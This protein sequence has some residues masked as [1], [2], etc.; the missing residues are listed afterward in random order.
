MTLAAAV[1]FSLSQNRLTEFADRSRQ[2]QSLSVGGIACP[3]GFFPYDNPKAAPHNCACEPQ[4][5]F[6]PTSSVWKMGNTYSIPPFFKLWIEV[7]ILAE[8]SCQIMRCCHKTLPFSESYPKTGV[9]IL[10]QNSTLSFWHWRHH[11]FSQLPIT[12]TLLFI[13]L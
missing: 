2:I 6:C 8:S 7:K 3:N 12:K 5:S 9:Y 11:P 13:G 10:W 4:P 1:S